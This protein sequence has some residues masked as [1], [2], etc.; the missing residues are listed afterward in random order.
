MTLNETKTADAREEEAL[1]KRIKH[2]YKVYSKTGDYE[3]L[4]KENS[5]KK[6]LIKK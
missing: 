4:R 5:K 1:K 3:V 2:G 6:V